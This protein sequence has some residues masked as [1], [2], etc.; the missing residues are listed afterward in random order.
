MAEA[1]LAVFQADME[2][3]GEEREAEILVV[4]EEVYMVMAEE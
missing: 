1:N 4:Y 2:K 3:V